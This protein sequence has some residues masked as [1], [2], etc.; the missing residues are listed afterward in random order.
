MGKRGKIKVNR[1]TFRMLN[2]VQYA[3]NQLKAEEKYLKEEP[4][5][6]QFK[7]FYDEAFTKLIA[8]K[9][10]AEDVLG[11]PVNAQLDG[12][13]TLGIDG[14]FDYELNVED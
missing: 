14:E 2:Y 4:D 11:I 13:V 8:C 10:M 9:E 6:P 7:E 1:M 12:K 3:L 5:N